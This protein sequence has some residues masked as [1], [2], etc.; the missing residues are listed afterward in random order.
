MTA[1]PEKDPGNGKINLANK[2][3]TKLSTLANIISDF[4][5]ALKH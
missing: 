1:K 4:N 3:Y 5:N 2:K